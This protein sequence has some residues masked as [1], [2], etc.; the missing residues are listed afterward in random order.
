[1]P[2]DI[3]I[4]GLIFYGCFYVTAFLFLAKHCADRASPLHLESIRFAP[5]VQYN[6]GYF[7]SDTDPIVST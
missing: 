4:S 3:G 6:G 2:Y 5:D 1:M 7:S